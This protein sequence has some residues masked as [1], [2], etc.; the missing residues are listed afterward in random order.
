MRPVSIISFP[1]LIPN[2]W[3]VSS[4]RLEAG[5]EMDKI[6]NIFICVKF[7]WSAVLCSFSLLGFLGFLDVFRFLFSLSGGG[8]HQFLFVYV[9]LSP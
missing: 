8:S 2:R 9:L 7:S 5:A 3:G 4:P 1:P 6:R